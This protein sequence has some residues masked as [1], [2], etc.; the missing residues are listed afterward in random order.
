[1]KGSSLEINLL[2]HR[3]YKHEVEENRKVLAP[4]TDTIVKLGRLGLPFRGYR[5]DSEYH[6]KV[7]EYST[8]GVGNFVEFLQF[9]VRGGDKVLKQ[10]LKTGSEKCE[11]YFKNFAN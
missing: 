1:M 2:C 5:D 11:L 8:G 9:M 7:G 6:S 10:H 4:I 3:K